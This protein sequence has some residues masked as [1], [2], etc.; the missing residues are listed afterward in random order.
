MLVYKQK[1]FD[2]VLTSFDSAKKLAIIKEVKG[3]LGIGLKD[4]KEMVEKVPAT[5]KEKADI[6]EGESLKEKL[7]KLGAVITLK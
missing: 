1:H 2:V 5:L 7:E 6:E 4:A 3:I